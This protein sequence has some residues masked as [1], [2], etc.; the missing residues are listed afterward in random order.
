MLIIP[1]V[2]LYNT[3]VYC[4]RLTRLKSLWAAPHWGLLDD[5]VSR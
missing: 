4:D 3:Q 5:P 2:D 1:V